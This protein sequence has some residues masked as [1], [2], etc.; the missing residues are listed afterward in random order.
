M[1]SQT[2]KIKE[3]SVSAFLK[4][5]LLDSEFILNNNI[6]HRGI[7]ISLYHAMQ[8][9]LHLKKNCGIKIGDFIV[10]ELSDTSSGSKTVLLNTYK[11]E[12]INYDDY[13]IIIQLIDFKIE[14]LDKTKNTYE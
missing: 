1:E 10:I 13:S 2:V 12:A 9:Q 11:Y 7:D 3:R 8:D 5:N 6:T 14:C 4:N